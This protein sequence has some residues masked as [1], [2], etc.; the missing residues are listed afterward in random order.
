MTHLPYG[1]TVRHLLD[2]RSGIRF[3]ENYTDADAEVRLLEQAIDWAPRRD[4]SVPDTLYG[5][6]ATLESERAHGGAFEYRSCETDVLGWVCEAAAGTRMADLVHDLVWS[7]I[8]A[9][10]AASTAVDRDGSGMCDGGISATLR[11]LLRL[12]AVWLGDGTALDGR[13]VLSPT[14]ISET[15]AG[16]TG[17]AD[18]F[19]ASK[20]GPWMPGGMYRTRCGSPPR[21][22]TS[23]CAW[24]STGRWSMSTGPRSGRREA[25][26]LARPPGSR[27]AVLD[28]GRL[29][30]LD[31]DRLRGDLGGAERLT[32]H[33]W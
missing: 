15:L 18:V 22:A 21:D 19:A 27:Q 5:F 17:A 3:S 6:V 25:V 26:Q 20:D 33:R 9:E 16:D 11:D 2:M 13:R 23:C 8:G 29:P 12:G 1:A 32:T 10:F 31:P 24:G 14:W 28:P 7:P 30:V 4:A